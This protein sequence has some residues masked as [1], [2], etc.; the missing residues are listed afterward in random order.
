VLVA[1]TDRPDIW[2]LQFDPDH[3]VLFDH[4]VDH[5]PGMVLMEG[6][7]Q[8]ALLTVRHPEALPLRAL[9]TFTKYI[10][11]DEPCLITAKETAPA[12]D[13]ARVVRVTAR[14]GDET[15]ASGTLDMFLP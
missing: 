12:R 11:F 14:Q 7:R 4:P 1:E 8:A 2:A 5:V 13:G 9:F 3:P 10:E 15:V 6:A